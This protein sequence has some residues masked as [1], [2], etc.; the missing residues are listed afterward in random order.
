[1]RNSAIILA[2]LLT[3]TPTLAAEQCV[4]VKEDPNSAAPPTYAK[5]A[6]TAHCFL[7]IDGKVIIDRTCHISISG[8]TH[9]WAMDGV[10]QA[11]MEGFLPGRPFYGYFCRAKKCSI[12]PRH[13]EPGGE[14]AKTEEELRKQNNGR[15]WVN[16]GRVECV[17]CRQEHICWGNKRFQMCF[18]RPYLICDPETIKAQQAN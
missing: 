9:G 1:M 10:A 8:D 14:P 3:A 2:V 11:H 17:D 4:E 5:Y 13:E 15:G 12:Q 18:A 7:R 16:Y 6:D